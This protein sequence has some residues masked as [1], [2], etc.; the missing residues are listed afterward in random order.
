MT[1]NQRSADNDGSALGAVGRRRFVRGTIGA[2]GAV[3]AVPALSGVAAA[4]FP[5]ELDIDV[6]PENEDNYIDLD[7]DGNVPVAVLPT[8]FL[9]SD[10]ER[11][12]FDPTEADV[13]YRFGSWSAL[14]DGEG[15]RPVDD[16]EVTTMESGHG[17]H[18]HSHEALMLHFPAGESGLDSADDVAWVYW[19]RDDSGEHGYAGFDSVTVV[20]GEPSSRDLIDLLRDLLDALHGE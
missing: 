2:V 20:G 7:A 3:A 16:G 17:D 6:Q 19:E 12:T 9:N 10:G 13:R 18:T 14:S 8:E 5:A 11:E 15:A 4:H 1:G